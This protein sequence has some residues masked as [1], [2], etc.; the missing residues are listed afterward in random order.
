MFPENC[1]ADRNTEINGGCA[2]DPIEEINDGF[3]AQTLQH[4]YSPTFQWGQQMDY[5]PLPFL[6]TARSPHPWV[7]CTPK[8][9][10]Q[11]SESSSFRAILFWPRTSTCAFPQPSV[12]WSTLKWDV[13]EA[14][15]YSISRSFVFFYFIPNQRKS[16][17]SKTLVQDRGKE[18]KPHRPVWKVW[19]SLSG[20]WTEALRTRNWGFHFLQVTKTSWGACQT[21]PST[22]AIFSA[23]EWGK[24]SKSSVFQFCQKVQRKICIFEN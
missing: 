9:L 4:R 24:Q 18:T 22:C 3:T 11:A 2:K 15:K 17:L 12:C 8:P 5:F 19:A 23:T 16:R 7:L 13:L 6:Q 10:L 20:H 14:W 1:S 21:V